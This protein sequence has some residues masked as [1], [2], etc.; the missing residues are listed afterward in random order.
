MNFSR[1]QA[2]RQ[3]SVLAVEGGIL[4]PGTWRE[5][6][7]RLGV[8]PAAFCMSPTFSAGLEARLYGRQ[9]CLTATS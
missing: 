2:W 4:P 1:R 9:G 6:R 5:Q 8:F 7:P 3:A